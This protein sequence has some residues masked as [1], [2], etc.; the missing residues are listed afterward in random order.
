MKFLIRR[1]LPM[2]QLACG[3]RLHL[4]MRLTAILTLVGSLHVCASTYSQNVSITGNDLS[5]EKIFTLLRQQTGCQVIYDKEDLR[6]ASAIDISVRDLPLA[7]FLDQV[8]RGTGLTYVIKYNTVIIKKAFAPVSTGD[9]PDDAPATD[10]RGRV[11]DTAY[12]P[13]MDATVMV[14]RTRKGTQTDNNGVFALKNVHEGDTLEI[15]FQGFKTREYVIG[16]NETFIAILLHISTDLLDQVQVI[17]YGTTI[18][19]YN[20]GSVST[21][22][23]KEIEEQPVA[24]PLQALQGRVPGLVVTNTSGAPGAM[25]L[26]QIRGQNTLN[27]NIYDQ[28]LYIIDGVPYAPQN[29]NINNTASGISTIQFTSLAAGYRGGS[30]IYN[31]PYGGISP[32]NS[33]NPDDIESISVLRD[34]DATAI[35][36]SQGSNGVVIITT[37][38]GKSG[39]TGLNLSVNS[40]PTTDTRG[41]RMMN[42]RQYLA[43]RH[44]AIQNDGLTPSITSPRNDYDLLTFDTTKYTNW[45]HQ[46]LG[47]TAQRVDA[48]G[49]ISGGSPNTTFLIGAG[50]TYSS[51]NFPGDFADNRFSLHTSF[52]HKSADQRL[53]LDFGNDFSY[54]RNNASGNPAVYTAFTLAPDFPDL[55]DKKGNLLWNYKGVPYKLLNNAGGTTANPFAYLKQA[56]NVGNLNL[57][58]HLQ[59]GYQLLSSLKIGASIG[60]SRLEDKNY[61]SEPIASIDPNVGPLLGY[62]VFGTG[63]Y[64][65]LNIEPQLN[66]DRKIGRGRLTLVAGGTYRQNISDITTLGGTGYTNDALLNSI[67]NAA[68]VIVQANY[69]QYKYVGGFGRMNFLWDNKYILNF[70][71]NRDGSS[72]FGPGRQFGNFGSAGAGWIFSEESFFKK[73]ISFISLG[74]LSANYGIRGSDGVN[75]YSYQ[76]NWKQSSYS[77]QGVQGFGPI[78]LFNPDYSW[79]KN[80]TVNLQLELGFLHDRI[81]LDVIGYRSRS[82]DQLASYNLPIQTGFSSVIMNAP[83]TVQNEGLEVSI[84]SKNIQ[85]KNFQWTTRFNISHNENKLIAFPNLAASSYASIY[86]VG[87]PTTIRHLVRYA[88]INDT[89]GIFQYY[90]GKGTLT[91]MPNP[92]APTARGGDA[93]QTVDVNP[94]FNG[95]LSNEFTYKSISLS[96]FLQFAKQRGQNYL[97]SVYTMSNTVSTAG[98]VGAAGMNLPVQFANS[99]KQP[100]DKTSIQRLTTGLKSNPTASNAYYGGFYFYTST[101]AYSDASYMRV[102]NISLS[103]TLPASMVKKAGMRSCI[104]SANAQNLFTITPY[105]VGDPETLFLYA[106]P[107]QRTV[108]VALTINF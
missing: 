71:G 29:R 10:I 74:K 98:G 40:G 46:F 51:Y 101:A 106:I 83:Y 60:Y 89:T 33:L 30:D 70:T 25:V 6:S 53:T 18:Q 73:T 13:L 41:V 45:Y 103:Y 34:A 54:D 2:A 36:G 72:N 104:I 8:L 91:Y 69:A 26:M 65:T 32:F 48:H 23:A 19:R 81:Y 76:P 90:T 42:T 86:V 94:S 105:K 108:V 77:Y 93:T 28:P 24:N 16:H 102:K 22:S 15:S 63:I 56:G 4:I 80:K 61:Y 17:A 59:L 58:T 79:D 55:L 3:K 5:L 87:K 85:T 43:M 27:V 84:F 39:K 82:S 44:Q 66:F 75:P 35:Y 100:G 92:T 37:K 95:G 64:Q 96:V 99:W 107:P 47:R 68:S 50:Y 7:K 38:K 11:S 97:T 21:V 20:V 52:S 1:M 88:G 49:A 62:A 31:N 78:N 12:N 9:H 57:N 14:K 67:A